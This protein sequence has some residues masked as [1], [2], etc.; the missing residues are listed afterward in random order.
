MYDKRA[1]HDR[2]YYQIGT[3]YGDGKMKVNETKLVDRIISNCSS[4]TFHEIIS[5]RCIISR[6]VI[7]PWEETGIS[8]YTLIRNRKRFLF[9]RVRFIFTHVHYVRINDNEVNRSI[10]LTNLIDS[11]ARYRQSDSD[12]KKRYQSRFGRFNDTNTAKSRSLVVTIFPTIKEHN[13]KR[14]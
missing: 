14:K 4:L 9:V 6:C 12:F 1:S 13:R 5:Q 2:Y 7:M 10:I 11:M 3:N 8:V